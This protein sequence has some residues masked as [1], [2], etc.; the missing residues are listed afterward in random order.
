MLIQSY[1]FLT[2]Y[3]TSGVFIEEQ[4]AS[5]GI[6]NDRY[7]RHRLPDGMDPLYMSVQCL[8]SKCIV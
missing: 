1:F 2:Y 6:I 7:D 3:Q 8:Q 4:S 5:G